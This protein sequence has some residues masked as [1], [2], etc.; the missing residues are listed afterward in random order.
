MRQ[1]RDIA[2]QAS[3]DRVCKTVC[4]FVELPTDPDGRHGIPVNE[5]STVHAKRQTSFELGANIFHEQRDGICADRHFKLSVDAWVSEEVTDR[6]TVSVRGGVVGRIVAAENHLLFL[7]R[8]SVRTAAC[9]L[10]KLVVV[11]AQTVRLIECPNTTVDFAVANFLRAGMHRRIIVVAIRAVFHEAEWLRTFLH[12]LR[13][14]T[15]IVT[16]RVAV[17]RQL[18]A[19]IRL[20]IAVVIHTVATFRRARVN[21]RIGIV[22]IIAVRNR[23][24]QSQ[25]LFDG[26]FR[27]AEAVAVVVLIERQLH[28]FIHAVHTVVIHTVA[29]FRRSGVNLRVLVV[30][31]VT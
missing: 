30:A 21:V 13:N 31:V 4:Q 8:T 12:R 1:D 29:D 25:A 24:R 22:T 14:I 23:A 26:L 2:W 3:N 15:E 16:V 5:Y 9:V 18:G 6:A 27:I 20:P 17:E 28:V 11:F 19:F 7:M 10:R